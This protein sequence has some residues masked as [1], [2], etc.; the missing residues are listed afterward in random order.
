MITFASVDLPDP[1]GPMSAWI[2]PLLTFRSRPLR[3]SLSPALACRLRISRSAIGLRWCQSKFV[4]I[5]GP[6]RRSRA[7][8]HGCR[9]VAAFGELDEVGQRR[10]LEGFDYAALDSHP[11]QL[12]RTRVTHVTDVRAGDPLR[13]KVH[14]ALHRRDRALER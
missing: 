8:R 10:A 14:E 12:G 2:S 11:Q 13:R 4:S 1:F 7:R 6:A 9:L 3:I 5:Y